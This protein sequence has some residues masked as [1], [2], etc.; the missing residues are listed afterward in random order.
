MSKMLIFLSD[1]ENSLRL[2]LVACKGCL[3]FEFSL[4]LGFSVALFCAGD[5]LEK[6]VFS[7]F[8]V[9]VSGSSVASVKQMFRR[10][11]NSECS[12]NSILSPFA[13]SA[14]LLSLG[15]RK[16][17]DLFSPVS[18]FPSIC[19]LSKALML[20]CACRSVNMAVGVGVGGSISVS[21]FDEHSFI[22]LGYSGTANFFGY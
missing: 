4:P 8:F 17:E 18:Q 13:H 7:W 21:E 16:I 6:V 22:Y 3:H 14:I 12:Y 9:I 2:L 5:F 1:F 15:V 19:P 11:W 20:V 10:V